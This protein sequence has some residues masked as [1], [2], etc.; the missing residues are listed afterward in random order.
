MSNETSNEL[1]EFHQVPDAKQ[2]ASFADHDLW[3][4]GDAVCPPSGNGADVIVIEF[5]QEMSAAAVVPLADAHELL[6]AERMEW[7]GYTD[8]VH[9]GD[10]TSCIL[11]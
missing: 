7:M 11:C 2:S 3:I 9:P 5:Q 8:K 10:G 4:R 1:G 6:S